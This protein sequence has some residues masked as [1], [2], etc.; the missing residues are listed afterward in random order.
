MQ[1]KL[2]EMANNLNTNP[3]TT[4]QL[5]QLKEKFTQGLHTIMSE[6]EN[7]AKNINE[8]S[9]KVQEGIA[10]LTKQAV[11]LAVQASQ[12]LNNQLKQATTPKNA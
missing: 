7:V 8:N 6:S 2:S 10:E 12:N 3:E 1:T 4:E 5:N 11:D 9:A